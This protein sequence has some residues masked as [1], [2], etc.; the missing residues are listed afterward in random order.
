[1]SSALRLAFQEG[2]AAVFQS[3]IWPSILIAP[4]SRNIELIFFRHELFSPLSPRSIKQAG[5]KF[6]SVSSSW[7]MRSEKLQPEQIGIA[8]F[9][10]RPHIIQT[11]RLLL[12]R[13]LKIFTFRLSQAWKVHCS[14]PQ[15]TLLRRLGTSENWGRAWKKKWF[16]SRNSG[17]VCTEVINNS[18]TFIIN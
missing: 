8:G 13:V 9:S 12:L 3:K 15:G 11:A 2:C 4:N 18:H 17:F 1:M 14:T 10:S 7:V 6:P 16:W 5:F